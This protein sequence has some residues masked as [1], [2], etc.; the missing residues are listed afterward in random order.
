MAGI[1][2]VFAFGHGDRIAQLKISQETNAGMYASHSCENI[3]DYPNIRNSPR[4]IQVVFFFCC[5]FFVV[6]DFILYHFLKCMNIMHTHWKGQAVAKICKN[7]LTQLFL[8]VHLPF[9]DIIGLV[10]LSPFSVQAFHKWL[11]QIR[12]EVSLSP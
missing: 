10:W 9:R 1:S 6:C 5:F 8:I 7:T 2:I 3:H 4:S 12:S 11:V